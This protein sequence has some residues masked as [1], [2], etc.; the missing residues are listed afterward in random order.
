LITRGKHGVS[1][2]EDG[3]LM[4]LE[5]PKVDVV[6][7]TGAGDCFNAPFCFGLASGWEWERSAAFAVRAAS[8][9]VK[10]FGAQAG[11]PTLDEVGL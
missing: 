11:M 5:A 3:E 9:S 1:F 10:K 7:T 4:N 8:R 2:V 6:D